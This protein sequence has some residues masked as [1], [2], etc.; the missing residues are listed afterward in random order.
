MSDRYNVSC[1]CFKL[2]FV[3]T[4][5][6]ASQAGIVLAAPGFVFGLASPQ[7]QID[8]K[9]SANIRSNGRQEFLN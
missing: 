2:S 7:C 4:A 3:Y 6:R 1:Q 5:R 9:F 8:T